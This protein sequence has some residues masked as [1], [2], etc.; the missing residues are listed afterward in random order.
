MELQTYSP[1][2]RNGYVRHWRRLKEPQSYICHLG[3]RFF[4]EILLKSFLQVIFMSYLS[5]LLEKGDLICCPHENIWMPQNAKG[6]TWNSFWVSWESSMT[7]KN[8][9]LCFV[10]FSFFGV[11]FIY[12]NSWMFRPLASINMNRNYFML[13]ILKGKKICAVRGVEEHC[14][15]FLAI[16]DA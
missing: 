14:Y 7:L 15:W 6:W 3:S 16:N 8:L 12:D 5:H 2:R 11:S 4:S 13:F 10:P 9:I 1:R